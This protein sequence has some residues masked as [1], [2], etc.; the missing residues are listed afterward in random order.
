M[1]EIK[2]AVFAA[3]KVLSLGIYMF[4]LK[5]NE[6]AVE[7]WKEDSYLPLVSNQF[8]KNTTNEEESKEVNQIGWVKQKMGKLSEEI[9]CI[10]NIIQTSDIESRY[11]H[12]RDSLRAYECGNIVQF[13]ESVKLS[14]YKAVDGKGKL[15]NVDGDYVLL[16]YSILI[17]AGFW[18]MSDFGIHYKSYNI[19]VYFYYFYTP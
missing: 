5:C 7:Q 12:L 13:K 16:V 4:H 2:V 10:S 17:F 11:H 18:V 3:G 8:S 1:A 19:F 14:Y 6:Y 9:E 15:R